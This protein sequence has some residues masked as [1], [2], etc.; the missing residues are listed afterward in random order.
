[1]PQDKREILFIAHRV[2]Y[3]PDRGDKIRSW[4]EF[5]YLSER[6]HV[7]L[8]ALADDPRD[9]EH[10]AVLD[11]VA[12]SHCVVER[13][14]TDLWRVA[15]GF[16][17]HEPLSVALFRKR[18]LAAYIRDVVANRPLSAVF[19][20][21][22]QMAGY[23]PAL[24]PSVRFV[25]DFCDVDSAKF[26]AYGREGRGPMAMVY[27]RESALLASLEVEVARRASASLFVSEAEATLF[28]SLPGAGSI[29]TTVVE[30]GVDVRHYDPDEHYP[31]PAQLAGRDGPKIVFTGQMDYRP[32]VEAVVDFATNSF[33]AIRARHADAWFIIVG[34]NPNDAVRALAGQPG[35][36][37]TGEVPD[38]R[39]YLTAADVVVAPLRIAR[40]IQN[41]V[42]EAM[43]MAKP[44]VASA[45]AAEGID[46]ES[47][48]DLLVASSPAAEA[49]LV[50]DM[51]GHSDR[52]AAI[53]LAARRRV[54]ERYG[55][56]ATLASLD[57]LVLG[58][59]A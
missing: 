20:Y 40:G 17:R 58:D 14:S 36:L 59:A 24:G 11:Q 37:I 33:P 41:K 10:D 26:A 6:A 53:G 12:A 7:H 22:G 18:K 43:A 31:F 50:L 15:N 4:H 54:V 42:L 52:A 29:A 19:V 35:V 49:G 2:P 44:V 56:D 47:G 25:M 57:Q 8:A 51:L 3:P 48:R 16:L 30:N 32:N 28:R 13:G 23:V 46:A 5:R 21:S 55:W 27:R 9:L 45:Q 1:M 38:V 39:P 34:R